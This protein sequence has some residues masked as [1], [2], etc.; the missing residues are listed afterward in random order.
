[1]SRIVT[2]LFGGKTRSENV[3]QRYQPGG[4]TTAGTSAVYNPGTRTYTVAPTEARRTAVANIVSGFNAQADAIKGLRGQV[5]PGFGR[6]TQSIKDS[7]QQRISELRGIGRKTVGNIRENLARRRLAGSSFQSSEVAAAEAEFAQQEDRIRAE[8]QVAEAQSF[9]Q[10]FS[11]NY[12]LVQDEFQATM[13]GLNTILTDLNFDTAVA[14]Q[15]T[16]LGNSLMAD[17]IRA[18]AEARSA[19]EA[20]GEDFLGAIMS[21]FDPS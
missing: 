12:G 21:M 7:A 3:L 8:T 9:L 11:M 6:L 5:E 14:A 18:Q 10:E 2:G 16:G 19:G 1:M 13:S 20:A 17:N 4:F 15:L